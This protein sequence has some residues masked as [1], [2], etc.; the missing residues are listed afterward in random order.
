[1]FN[2]KDAD[3]FFPNEYHDKIVPHTAL[4]QCSIC[5]ASQL[6]KRVKRNSH[7]CQLKVQ[8]KFSLHEENKIGMRLCASHFMSAEYQN[9]SISIITSI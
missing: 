6:N 2:D 4:I 5:N 1:M 7:V 8:Y 3:Y 9:I